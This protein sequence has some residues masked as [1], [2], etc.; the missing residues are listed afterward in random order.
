MTKK[1]P[2]CPTCKHWEEVV[3]AT[4]PDGA[5]FYECENCWTVIAPIIDTPTELAN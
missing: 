4:Y 2:E 5:S 3:I 1:I